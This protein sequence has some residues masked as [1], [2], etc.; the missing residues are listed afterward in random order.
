MMEQGCMYEQCERYSKVKSR[1]TI[2][3]FGMFLLPFFADGAELGP[4][5]SPDCF[6]GFGRSGGGGCSGGGRGY[7][8][9]MS[10][11]VKLPDA[12]ASVDRSVHE[13]IPLTAEDWVEMGAVLGLGLVIARDLGG[14]M[15]GKG[16]FSVKHNVVV[17]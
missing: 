12:T 7:C 15:F 13:L 14:Y 4:V 10:V 3:E 11:T 6:G 5:G 17:R 16:D 9:G 8:D 2:Y 1:S